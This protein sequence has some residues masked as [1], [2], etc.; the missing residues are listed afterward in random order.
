MTNMNVSAIGAMIEFPFFHEINVNGE[1]QLASAA[2]INLRKIP[3]VQFLKD[4]YYRTPAGTFVKCMQVT[5]RHPELHDK[6]HED[7]ITYMG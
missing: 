6:F 1:K 3:V 7:M 5:Q 4:F 2:L